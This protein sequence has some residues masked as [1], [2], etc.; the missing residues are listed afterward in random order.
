MSLE[1]AKAF[2]KGFYGRAYERMEEVREGGRL[3][4]ICVESFE[5]D[6]R[7]P[8]EGQGKQKLLWR[9]TWDV[10]AGMRGNEPK[11]MQ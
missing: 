1:E 6:H 10:E 8:R 3:R 4:G 2:L 11:V 7:P 5:E 9:Y